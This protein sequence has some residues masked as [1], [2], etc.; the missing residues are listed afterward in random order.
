MQTHLKY[1]K[2][3]LIFGLI[4]LLNA[5]ATRQTGMVV[6]MPQDSKPTG[7]IGVTTNKQTSS[8][9][10]PWQVVNVSKN[11]KVKQ[12]S[13]AEEEVE[14]IFGPALSALPPE[15]TRLTFYFETGSAELTTDSVDKLKTLFDLIK[16]R[17]IAE[18]QITGHTDT[19]G[20]S[21]SNDELSANRAILMRDLLL[22]LLLREGVSVS[23]IIIAGRG[24]RELFIATEDN[25]EEPR[26]RRV[27]ITVR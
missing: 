13:I 8:I 9:N 23:S 14:K 21:E 19:F 4:I 12:E 20:T 7:E 5:C 24:E 22:D 25:V 11:G 26:N 16:Q 1:L 18:I 27:E 15:P 3:P 17:Q 10:Q 2:L 6:L